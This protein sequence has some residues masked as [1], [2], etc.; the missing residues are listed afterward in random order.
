MVRMV[1]DPNLHAKLEGVREVEFCDASGRTVGHFLSEEAYRRLL[2]EWAN[3]QISDEE[4]QRRLEEP[5]GRS[6]DEILA[7][8][9]KR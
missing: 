1:L 3:A 6:L 5:G 2:Y 4:L 7:D 8:L 9:E